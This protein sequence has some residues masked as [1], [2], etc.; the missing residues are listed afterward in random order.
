MLDGDY[1]ILG[2]WDLDMGEWIMTK[3][4]MRVFIHKFSISILFM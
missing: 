3:W 4:T 2:C 1:W